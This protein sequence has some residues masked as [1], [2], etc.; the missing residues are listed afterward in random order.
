MSNIDTLKNAGVIA[1]N[2]TFST[3]DTTLIESLLQPEV[4]AL[5]SVSGKLNAEFI[6]RNIGSAGAANKPIGIVF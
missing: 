2:A 4:D 6:A 3:A 5:I 1:Q